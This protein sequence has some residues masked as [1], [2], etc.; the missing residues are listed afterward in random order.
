MSEH[1]NQTDAAAADA[2]R[3][4]DF[5]VAN[6]DFVREDA[7]LFSL[8]IETGRSDGAIDLGAAA[9][10]K[11]REEVRQLKS[12]NA[13]IVETARA[14]LAT[15]SQIH[16]AVLA[17]LEVD[18][19]AGLDSKMSNRLTGAL[20]IDACRVLIEGHAPLKD[21]ESILGAAEGFVGDVLGDHVE[22]LGPVNPANA[23][24]LYGQQGARVSSQAIV[25]LDFGGHDGLMALAARDAH[26]FQA[27][28]GTE[29]LNFLA[30]AVERMV[31]Q[32]LHQN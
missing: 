29:L 9:R 15:Q 7:E 30:R 16:M 3:I 13:S 8:V 10:D 32:W 2:D 4:R 6:P 19:L 17:L 5:L 21:A 28:Q 24:A 26:L 27:G 22:L 25:R 11:L 14:N 23:H 1:D 12:L 31:V 18:S 20:G